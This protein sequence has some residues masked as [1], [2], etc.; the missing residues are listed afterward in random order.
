[1]EQIETTKPVYGEMHPSILDLFRGHR[2][3]RVLEDA[4]LEYMLCRRPDRTGR[5]RKKMEIM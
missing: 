5:N 2:M 1:M 3:L 4:Q